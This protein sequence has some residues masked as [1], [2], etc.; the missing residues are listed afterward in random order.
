[1][2]PETYSN[3]ST[4]F[5]S[6]SATLNAQYHEPQANGELIRKRHHYYELI[7]HASVLREFRSL[8]YDVHWVGT[9]WSGTETS[10]VADQVHR[11]SGLVFH[12]EFAA[13]LWR[14]TPLRQ[15]EPTVAH[16]HLFAFST[17]ERIARQPEPTYAFAHVLAP[18][19]PYVF[20]AAGNIIANVPQ[21]LQFNRQV[22]G[23]DQRWGNIDAYVAQLQ[24]INRRVLQMVDTILSQPGPR[25]IILLQS[26]HGSAFQFG[27]TPDD[28]AVAR[29]RHGVLNAILAPAEWQAA[30]PDRGTLVNTYPILLR[31]GFG[32]AVPR[33]ADRVYYS[34]YGAAHRPTEL[35][36]AFGLTETPVV[37][38]AEDPPD[39]AAV[40]LGR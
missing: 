17:L 2:L 10:K 32:R 1:M 19:N 22:F 18:H 27:R 38:E 36:Q 29:E 13:V 31:A 12:S 6:L 35:T 30:F 23:A 7:R 4:T 33:L 37:E 8:G 40:A 39:A 15:F 20:D 34:W 26:D 24:F 3:Y 16:T 11:L 14:R 9:T 28:V 25:P 21:V 5:L